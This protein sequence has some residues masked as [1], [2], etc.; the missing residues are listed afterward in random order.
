MEEYMKLLILAIAL[1]FG[2][3]FTFAQTSQIQT[4]MMLGFSATN[5]IAGQTTVTATVMDTSGYP[6]P[7]G[8]FV[9]Y[10]APHSISNAPYEVACQGT[11]S[12]G[13]GKCNWY[14]DPPGEFHV[15]GVYGGYYD[16][17]TQSWPYAQSTSC[18]YAVVGGPSYVSPE[19]C[20][21]A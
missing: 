11:I 14:I 20:G 3:C 17:I 12:N 15:Y 16:P 19:P 18:I 2:S 10:F 21:Y 5:S 6:V 8:N 7:E 13:V 9:V 1:A 4:E